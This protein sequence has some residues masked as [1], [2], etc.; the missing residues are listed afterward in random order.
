M[1]VNVSEMLTNTYGNHLNNKQ[2]ML[3]L[4]RTQIAAGTELF[5]MTFVE[6]EITKPLTKTPIS[7]FY[8]CHGLLDIYRL[9]TLTISLKIQSHTVYKLFYVAKLK[10]GTELLIETNY[11]QEE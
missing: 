5:I 10:Y 7:N 8:L 2:H 6:H 11:V 1:P 4:K 3:I 9:F